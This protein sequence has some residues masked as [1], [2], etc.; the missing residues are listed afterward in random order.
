MYESDFNLFDEDE[1]HC[2]K[3]R[4]FTKGYGGGIFLNSM[5]AGA[6]IIKQK[7]VC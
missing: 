2:S 1:I 5:S 7:V 3:S 4:L 6:Q